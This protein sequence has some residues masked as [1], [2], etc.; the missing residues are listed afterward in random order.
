MSLEKV[1]MFGYSP[2]N[3]PMKPENSPVE[4]EFP[5]QPSGCRGSVLCRGVCLEMFVTRH[6]W[7]NLRPPDV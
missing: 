6:V 7:V 3:D 4:E 5:L 2:A 1:V